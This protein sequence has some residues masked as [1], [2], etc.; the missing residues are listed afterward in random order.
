MIDLKVVQE[1]E[2]LS[3]RGELKSAVGSPTKKPAEKNGKK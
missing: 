1:K 2:V 3:F